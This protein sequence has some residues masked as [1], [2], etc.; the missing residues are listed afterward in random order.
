MKLRIYFRPSI[1]VLLLGIAAA[2]SWTLACALGPR[3]GLLALP[4]ALFYSA[5]L[6]LAAWALWRATVLERWRRWDAPRRLL[7]LAPHEDDC[8]IA[9]GG[10][11]LRN[12][13]LGGTTRIIYLAADE[14]PGMADRRLAEARAAWA[15][16]GLE[17]SDLRHHDLLPPLRRR[18]PQKLHA[19]AGIVRSII[20]DFGP[21]AVV[22][23][24][25]EGG[26]IHHDMIAALLGAVVTPADR[27]EVLEAPEYGPYLS[28]ANTPHRII[29]LCARW[30]FGL[31]AYYG[32]PDGIDGRPVDKI[33]LDRAELEGKR[34]MLAAFVSQN[35]PS[36]VATRSY[37]DRLVRWYPGGQRRRPFDVDRSYL[38]FVLA[39]RRVLPAGLVDRLLPGQLGTIGRENAVTDWH[40]EWSVEPR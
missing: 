25:F 37:P 2:S 22:V 10:L 36:L 27:F 15:Q 5:L 19:A 23:P 32:P 11:G 28:L 40:D 35:A 7:I 20:D 26:H 29:A 13:R 3:A 39:A 17:A 6:A 1:V 4:F 30:L 16:A 8:V 14:T 38:G 9:A 21:D 31:V 24:M 12:R 34:R 18:D 33:R